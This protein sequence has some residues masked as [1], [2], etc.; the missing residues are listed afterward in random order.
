[1][2]L[3][4]RSLRGTSLYRVHQQPHPSSLDSAA[5]LKAELHLW[6]TRTQGTASE[7]CSTCSTA[8]VESHGER[9]SEPY[10]TGCKGVCQRAAPQ[11][12]GLKAAIVQGI[13]AL[14]LVLLVIKVIKYKAEA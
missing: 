8:C 9:P 12:Q 11:T 1:M 13:S 2:A 10:H 5:C 6:M 7:G 3:T 4:R 14:L